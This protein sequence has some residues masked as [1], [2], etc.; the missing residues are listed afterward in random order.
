MNRNV[1]VYSTA[2]SAG[3]A[4]AW[5]KFV[6]RPRFRQA[7]GPPGAYVVMRDHFAVA[8]FFGCKGRLWPSIY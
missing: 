5:G 1:K 6:V 4:G 3:V 8:G 7:E 2:I